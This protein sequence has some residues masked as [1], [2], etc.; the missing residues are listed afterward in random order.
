M[1]ERSRSWSGGKTCYVFYFSSDRP[2]GT[3]PDK[4]KYI[5]LTISLPLHCNKDLSVRFV[6]WNNDSR[7]DLLV[8]C[9]N[10]GTFLIYNQDERETKDSWHLK[11]G[12]NDR[13]G[14]SDDS[15]SFCPTN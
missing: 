11:D 3:L 12:C 14:R 7:Q 6:D 13:G 5:G 9:K 2:Q 15:T 4:A 8:V 1:P 10:V